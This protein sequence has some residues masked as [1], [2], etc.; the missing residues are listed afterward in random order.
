MARGH[1]GDGGRRNP[2]FS[3]SV[4]RPAPAR[5]CSLSALAELGP[6]MLSL[7]TSCPWCY[8]GQPCCLRFAR[9]EG[10]RG[11]TLDMWTRQDSCHRHSEERRCWTSSFSASI[12]SSAFSSPLRSGADERYGAALRGCA[13]PCS[14]IP[15]T[16]GSPLVS[17]CTKAFF[18]LIF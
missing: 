18:S 11:T 13:P 5:P 12:S 17:A 1:G 9:K 6:A 7:H 3:S 4:I 2:E 15:P 8:R 16:R 10:L 14:G